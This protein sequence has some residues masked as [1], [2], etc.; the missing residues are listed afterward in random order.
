MYPLKHILRG[1]AASCLIF[2]VVFVLIPGP[3]VQWLSD[4]SPAPAALML[5]IGIVLILNG[6]HLLSTARLANIPRQLIIY[7]STMDIVWVV[8]TFVLILSKT[9]ITTQ[10]GIVA[11]TLVAI[12]VG[13]W[14]TLQLLAIRASQ[15]DSH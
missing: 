8:G 14:A 15:P 2:G 12:M 6:F 4:H 7:F 10:A 9:W 1:N 13:L 11:A 3:T 5:T